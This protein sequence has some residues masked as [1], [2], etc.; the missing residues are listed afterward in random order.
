MNAMLYLRPAKQNWPLWAAI[1]VAFVALVMLV[2]WVI[3]PAGG[4]RVQLRAAS[5]PVPRQEVSRTEA[6]APEP[7]APTVAPAMVRQS[8]KELPPPEPVAVRFKYFGKV[9]DE[10]R[11]SVV[12]YGGGRTITVRGT[13]PIGDYVVDAFEPGYVL[14]RHVALGST[15]LV[16]LVPPRQAPAAASP[17]DSPQD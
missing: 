7:A 2:R 16:E 13:G 14:I 17:E 12:L 15:Q 1:M 10:G 8:A 4:E 11:T 9:T 3:E 5:P 6:A